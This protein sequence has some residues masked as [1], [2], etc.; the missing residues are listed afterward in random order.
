MPR[1]FRLASTR[2]LTALAMTALLLAGCSTWRLQGQAP[3]TVVS[4]SKKPP[5]VRVTLQD[6]SKLEVHRAIVEGDSL[7]G[8]APDP[9]TEAKA[10]DVPRT[11]TS[12]PG[13][14]GRVAFAL[15][16]I[17]AIEIRAFSGKKTVL[18]IVGTYVVVTL[19]GAAFIAMD[20]FLS[21]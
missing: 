14:A 6:G 8:I 16:D 12:Y 3:A 10:W 9:K 20:D 2:K 7:V 18:V 21:H 17:R 4:T 5:D 1:D 15:S 19:A 13:E 11:P